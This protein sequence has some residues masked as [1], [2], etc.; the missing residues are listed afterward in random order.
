MGVI[1]GL[2]LGIPT[3]IAIRSFRG[4]KKEYI[5]TKASLPGMRKNYWNSLVNVVKFGAV[6]V[7]L[8]AALL[9][10]MGR[11]FGDAADGK[12]VTPG[13]SSSPSPRGER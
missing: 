5:A 6:L 3:G 10:W 7:V 2:M 12:P 8:A 4:A 9:T 13:S 11:E 1:V